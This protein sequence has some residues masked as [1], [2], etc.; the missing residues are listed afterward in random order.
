MTIQAGFSKVAALLA[1]PARE[2][3]LVALFDGR[4]LPAGELAEAAGVTPQSASGHLRKLVEGGIIAVWPQGRFRYFRLADEQV[5]AALEVLS[6]VAPRSGR[7]FNART[8]PAHLV[9]AR[10]CYNHLAGRLG[11]ALADAMVERSLIAI[12]GDAAAL[13]GAGARWAEAEGFPLEIKPDGPRR[14]RLCLDWTERRFH[15]AGRFPSGVLQQLLDDGRLARGAGR[16]LT[17]TAS[18][19]AWF[20]GLGVDA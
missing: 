13:T 12:A 19:R 1:D 9:H 20:A 3:M 11:V 5:A 17:V 4:A 18:G 7:P 2:A 15:L 10:C 14:L 16:G 8:R 6:G